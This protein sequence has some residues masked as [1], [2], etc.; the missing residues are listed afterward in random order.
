MS[1]I[2]NYKLTTNAEYLRVDLLDEIRQFTGKFSDID[3]DVCLTYDANMRADIAVG[4][5]RSH[6]TAALPRGNEIEIKRQVKRF[7]KHSLY[8]TLAEISGIALPWGSLTG[9][10][11]TKLA[12]A[13][14]DN[15]GQADGVADYMQRT[16]AVSS[17]RAKLLQRIIDI[18]RSALL[19]KPDGAV[20][21]YVHIPFCE[22]RCNYCSFPSVDISKKGSM[23]LLSRYVDALI[24]EIA[25]IKK[26]IASRS[27]H[28]F[29]VYVGGGTP[30]VL[31]END[32]E[33]LLSA[34]SADNC[35]FTFEA[36]RADSFSREK[37]VILR[38]GGVTRI[39]VNPQT[40]NDETLVRIGRRHNV[41][42]FYSAYYTAKEA[43]F[44]INTD[45][46]AGLEGETPNDF[47]RTA[48]GIAELQPDNVTVHTLSRKR[49][50]LL[51]DTELSCPDIERMTDYA[52]MRFS[53]YEPYYLYRQKNMVGNLEN[54]G[55][56]KKGKECVNNITVMEELVP[57]Y[58]CGAGSI[59]KRV[60]KYI[61][62]FASPK[63]VGLYINELYERTDKKLMFLSG[64]DEFVDSA[65]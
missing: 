34:I 32:L 64:K 25:E 62:R 43:G 51:A 54:V 57:V 21:L 41:A 20:N 28:I 9:I 48:D 40:L 31:G 11:P 16:F 3:I 58:A 52:F 13:Y 10:R 55:F 44:D 63:D 33:R 17:H 65:D 23:D 4:N 50:S 2:Y 12:Y 37:T 1:Y 30:S 5:I 26:F 19:N 18:Q 45:I 22:G 24:F 14:I 56:C 35:E 7:V 59:S 46:I 39:C 60:G 49:A 29:S 6:Y 61:S 27:E 8:L 38:E 47:A 15:G 53:D 36:G 42:D